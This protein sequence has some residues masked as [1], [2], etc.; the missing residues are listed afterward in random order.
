[1]KKYTDNS[2][3]ELPVFH[4]EKCNFYVTG[5]SEIKI[6]KKTEL[7]YKEKHWGNNNLWDAKDAIKNN[8][9]D[10]HSQ[11]KKDIGFH[12]TNIVNRI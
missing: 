4:C 6:K 5:E 10:I 12:N 8:Y 1:M 11:G 9:T 7:I 2:Y 3:L